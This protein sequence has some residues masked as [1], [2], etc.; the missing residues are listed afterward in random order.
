MSHPSY[1]LFKLAD[2]EAPNVEYIL[3]D[4]PCSGSGMTNRLALYGG[5]TGEVNEDDSR[6][7]KLSGLQYKMLK[8]AMTQFPHAKKITYSTCSLHQEENEK[9][10]MQ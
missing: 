10:C 6:M 4:P 8:H 7:C 5:T 2:T 1:S 9:V 3:L